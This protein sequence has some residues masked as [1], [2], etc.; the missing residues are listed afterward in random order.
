MKSRVFR[1]GQKGFTLMEILI[2][3]IIFVI[4]SVFIVSMTAHAL[5]KPKQAGIM[6]DFDSYTKTGSVLLKELDSKTLEEELLTELNRELNRELKFSEGVSE[7]VNPY[8][9]PY[10]V[11]VKKENT[12][13]ALIITTEGKKDTDIYSLVLLKE[14]NKVESCTNGFSKA[15][16]KLLTLESDLCEGVATPDP[17]NPQEPNEPSNPTEPGEEEYIPVTQVPEGCIGVYTAIDLNNIRNDLRGCY[18]LM[19]DIDLSMYFNWSPIG[20]SV[21]P[22]LG[23]LDGQNYKITNL[24]IDR[25]SSGVEDFGLFGN[26]VMATLQ[27]VNIVNPNIRGNNYVGALYG[28]GILVTVKDSKVTGGRITGALSEATGGLIG[29]A[30]KGV[31]SNS[32]SSTTITG[33]NI[34]GMLAGK[35]DAS[36]VT[37]SSSSGVLSLTQAETAGGLIGWVEQG[38]IYDSHSDVTVTSL[39]GATGGLIG[40]VH[41]GSVQNSYSTGKV[42]NSS[43]DTKFDDVTGGL[44]GAVKGTASVKESYYK[45]TVRGNTFTGG[46]VGKL[47]SGGVVEDSYSTGE[48][49]SRSVAGGLIGDIEFAEGIK[50]SNSSSRVSGGVAAGGLVGLLTN[51]DVYDSYA[52]GSVKTESGYLT[53][54]FVS[55]GLVA[56]SFGGDVRNNIIERSF[57]TGSVDGVEGSLASGFIGVAMYTTVRNSYSTGDV[58]MNSLTGE[59]PIIS[60][61]FILSSTDNTISNTYSTGKL[62][63][64]S[65]SSG[66]TYVGTRNKASGT[67]YY[68]SQTSGKTIDE[69][70][71][72][73]RTTSQMQRK[74][75]YVGWDFDTVWKI[76]E[77][78]GYPTLR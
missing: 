35:L 20:G 1:L 16:K 78:I 2:A 40:I 5:D 71:G 41:L 68:N 58:G 49:I 33:D 37:G 36:A 26:V 39:S 63:N 34:V 27:R 28:E 60:A 51:A 4:A 24:R 74:S 43:T 57:A 22:F 15:N 61:G 64:D 30:E 17:S 52:T 62:K 56:N 77:G 54:E 6:S 19:N 13:T 12:Q 9:K 69:V 42:T 8:T 66:Y 14:D 47:L 67:S 7:K 73:A 23:T 21:T 53:N 72:K 75:N 25:T 59:K 11:T 38:I 10:K 65:S 29:R 44:I 3:I 50:R 31:I 48:V 46:L 45:G 32:F 76:E 55:G 18:I 70:I